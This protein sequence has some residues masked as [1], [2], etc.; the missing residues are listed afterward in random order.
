MSFFRDM[1]VVVTGGC[2]MIGSALTRL[3]LD[4]GAKVTVLDNFSRGNI[5]HD[6]AVYIGGDAMNLETCLEVF[7]GANAVFNLAASV[8]GV[9]YNETHQ[10]IMFRDNLLLQTVPVLAAKRYKIPYFCQVSSSCVYSAHRNHPGLEEYGLVGEPEAANYGYAMAKRLGEMAAGEWYPHSVVVRPSN[11]YGIAD[12]YDD[13]AHVIPALIRKCHEDD[14]V[15]VM[16]TGDE[17]REFIYS[18]DVA[19][20]MMAAVQ[21]G[22]D[23][24]EHTFNIGTNGETRVTI[25]EL[26]KLIMDVMGI[27]KRIVFK[28]D[29]VLGDKERWTSGFLA[30]RQLHW[31]YSVGLREGLERT[32]K[33]YRQRFMS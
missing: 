14:V 19:T 10:S 5:Q 25:G 13:R 33:D 32:I 20:G 28:V 16:G 11:A 26:V 21:Y 24:W 3:L 18:D 2:G 31:T 30:K 4:A 22:H 17:V 29:K 15:V 27:S 8:A 7:E 12:H 6:R 9:F 23:G 1:S